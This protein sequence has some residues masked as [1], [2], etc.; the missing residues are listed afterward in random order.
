MKGTIWE[1][2]ELVPKLWMEKLRLSTKTVIENE[3]DL[4]EKRLFSPRQFTFWLIVNI[5]DM[6]VI[7]PRLCPV[8]INR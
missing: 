2:D 5:R 3:I 6:N 7:L 8:P 1:K 4:K